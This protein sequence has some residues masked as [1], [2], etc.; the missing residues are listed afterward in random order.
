MMDQED[1]NQVPVIQETFKELTENVI[2]LLNEQERNLEPEDPY[3][4]TRIPLT[5]LAVYSELIEALPSIEE[6]FFDTSLTEKECKETIHLCPRI[7][8]M[9]YHPPPMNESVSSAVKKADACL[10]GIQISLA[11][12]TRPIDHYVHRIIQENSQANSKDPHILFF[13]T[14]RVLLADIAETVTQDR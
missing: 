1:S 13:N 9:N 5:D 4:T 7:I 12:A 11:Q 6:D 2:K 8:S 3:V 10:H 14:M